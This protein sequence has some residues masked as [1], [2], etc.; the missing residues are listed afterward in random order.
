MFFYATGIRPVMIMRLPGNCSQCL[1][2]V[3]D[4]TVAYLDGRKAYKVTLPPNIPARAFSSIIIF[5]NQT[6]S[7]L[8][9]PKRYPR[10]GSESTRIPAAT[11]NPDGSTTVYLAPANPGANDGNAGAARA[12]SVSEGSSVR[13]W[14]VRPEAREWR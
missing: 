14:G 8:Q 12:G 4:S 2:A 10:A 9:T 3:V 13:R 7:M 5:D 6:R 1:G 11:A